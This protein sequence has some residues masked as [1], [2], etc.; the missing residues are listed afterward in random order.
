VKGK[1]GVP[2]GTR[3]V[4]Y[5]GRYADVRR[6]LFASLIVVAAMGGYFAN[7]ALAATTTADPPMTWTQL[8]PATSPTIRAFASMV[9]DPATSN[10]VLFGGQDPTPYYGDTWTWNG[11]TWTKKSPA[12]SPSARDGASMVY[13]AATGNVLLF[14]GFSG[15]ARLNDTWSWNGTTW[16]QLHPGTSP[17]IRA[18]ASM[19]YDPATGNVVLFGGE[20]GT[21]IS[22]T[23][24][25][26]TWVWNGT[27]WTKQTP[28][29]SPSVRY[30]ASMAYD[31]SLGKPVLFGG[32]HPGRLNDTWTWSGTTWTKL[33]PATSP[34]ARTNAAMVYD[35]ALSDLVLFGGRT[36]TGSATALSDT[37]T[38]NGTTWAQDTPTAHP[39]ARFA[40]SLV[41][42]TAMTL[43]LLFGGMNSSGGADNDTWTL[44][45]KTVPAKP[46]KPTG[47][48]GNG[49]VTVHWTAPTPGGGP[50]TGYTVTSSPTSKTCTGAATATSCIVTGLHNGTAYTFKV[51]A[52]NTYGTSPTSTPSTP[53]TPSGAPF[54]PAKP[55]ATPGNAKA[56]VHWTAPTNNGASITGYT[57]TSSPT[58]KTCT[59]G[60]GGSSCTV[61]GLHNG[62]AYTF[63]VRAKNINGT[64]PT[65]T[66]STAVTPVGPPGKPAP[67]VAHPG[68]HKAM[69]TWSAPAT[70]GG[71]PITGY[72][73]TSSPT[74][75]TCT[76]GATVT[77]CTVTGL[78]NGTTYTFRVR[79]RNVNGTGPTSTPST[80]AKPTGPPTTVQPFKLTVNPGTLTLTCTAATGATKPDVAT[81]VTKQTQAKPC[82]LITLG[83]VKLNEKRHTLTT[84]GHNLI[85]STARGAPTD[86]WALY[87]VMVPT[88]TVLTGNTECDFV[89][90]FCN[91]TTTNPTTFPSHINN[92][93]ITPNYLGVK[94]KCATN[95]TPATTF[96]NDNPEPTATAGVTP[97]ATG[98]SV[99]TKLCSATTGFSGGQFFVTTLDYTLIVPP[100]VYA[101]TYYGTVLYTLSSTAAKVPVNPT[102]PPQ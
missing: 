88:S 47:T 7:Q 14:G 52:K 36:T 22:P 90:G 32:Y 57:V 25:G 80:S 86:S 29:T 96:Y 8:H 49:Q 20:G 78:M 65:S 67:P 53:V 89:Q 39:S 58:S 72:T 16:T 40:P 48:H 70:D 21:L 101:G 37:W 3:V 24:L 10:V 33:T 59:T 94:S 50:I 45:V 51:K 85:I 4:T 75:K 69:V 1:G 68:S 15:S 9:Y 76:T 2:W 99:Q 34:T 13:D 41:Y 93:T 56:T 55:T 63:K 6:A 64:G 71:S 54:K 19:V 31:T 12:T 5:L 35:P 18:Y 61:T 73:V 87:A 83:N 74:A 42:D 77:S 102:T 43:P 62:T 84:N 28:A 82:T 17:T 79:A 30:F 11:T 100:T 98:L 97:G 81:D 26:D 44:T 46:A 95:D 27:T 23:F 38:F 60:G 92:T 91:R 66:P